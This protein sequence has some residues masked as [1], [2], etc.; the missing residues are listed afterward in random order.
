[1]RGNSCL[2]MIAAAVAVTACES[3][4]PPR[5]GYGPG[6]AVW[7]EVEGPNGERRVEFSC[8][9]TPLDPEADDGVDAI[10]EG[11]PDAYIR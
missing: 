5:D 11:G 9:Y 8:R 2:M 6:E 10:V 7:R 1:M 3:P 4:C